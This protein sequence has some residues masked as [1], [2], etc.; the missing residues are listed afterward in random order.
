MRKAKYVPVSSSCFDAGST[1]SGKNTV[2][3]FAL[4]LSKDAGQL[5]TVTSSASGK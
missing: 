3:S 4:K 1:H 2:A 5:Q